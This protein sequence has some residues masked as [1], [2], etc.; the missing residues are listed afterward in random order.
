[1]I[2]FHFCV[3]MQTLVALNQVTKQVINEDPDFFPIKPMD[4]GRFLIISI[5]TGTAK[6]EQKFNAKMASKWGLLDW[7]THGGSTPLIDVFSQSSADLVD[8]HLATVTQALHS[9]DNYL[10]IQVYMCLPCIYI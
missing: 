3:M 4:Y 5:G 1:M 6:N 9:Q 8:F 10:R 2:E 7:L